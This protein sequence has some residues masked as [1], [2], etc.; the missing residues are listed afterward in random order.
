VAAFLNPELA[1]ALVLAV[2]GSIPLASAWQNAV[3]RVRNPLPERLGMAFD[4]VAGVATVCGFAAVFAYSS[5]L[6]A[7]GAYSP[8]IY[9]RF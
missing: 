7:A 4:A 6:M 9:F 3:A 5:M 2:L 8:F 1:I